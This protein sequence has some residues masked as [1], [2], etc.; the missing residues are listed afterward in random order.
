MKYED[1]F[2]EKLTMSDKTIKDI[3]NI[4]DISQ[5]RINYNFLYNNLQILV[6]NIIQGF[7]SRLQQ[8]IFSYYVDSDFILIKFMFHRRSFRTDINNKKCL[9]C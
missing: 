6:W 3:L 5:V 8:R 9:L 4:N 2:N 1:V 7:I